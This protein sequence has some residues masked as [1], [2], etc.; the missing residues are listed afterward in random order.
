MR[1]LKDPQT[2]P[3]CERDLKEIFGE[4]AAPP[5]D[6]KPVESAK[7]LGLYDRCTCGEIIRFDDVPT[8]WRM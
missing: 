7:E 2:C 8:T 5:W 4:Q 3:R 1:T 6:G